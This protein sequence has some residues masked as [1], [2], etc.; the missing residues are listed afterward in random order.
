MVFF[1]L[2]QYLKLD[3]QELLL[4]FLLILFNP[5]ASILFNLEEIRFPSCR[6]KSCRCVGSQLCLV[7]L[8]LILHLTLALE[9]K[10][11][12]Q[13][14]AVADENLEA[15]DY[16]EIIVDRLFIVAELYLRLKT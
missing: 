4:Y 2:Y 3:P 10:A 13:K 12:V 14:L 16:F 11:M 5:S 7:L 1:Q 6:F 9:H 15:P 8:T